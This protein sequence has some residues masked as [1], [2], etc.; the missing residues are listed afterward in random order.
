MTQN[1]DFGRTWDYIARTVNE[2]DLGIWT[3][4]ADDEALA[5][6]AGEH[7]TAEVETVKVFRLTPQDGEE[8][9]GEANRTRLAE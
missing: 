7:I 5:Y 3:G 4:S 2:E 9:V 8:Y 6:F 1:A